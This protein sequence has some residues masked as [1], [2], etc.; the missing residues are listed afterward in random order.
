MV[1]IQK[2]FAFSSTVEYHRRRMLSALFLI[3]FVCDWKSSWNFGLLHASL[4]S[5][6]SAD[7]VGVSS[8]LTIGFSLQCQS[9]C[10]SNILS[11]YSLRYRL[12]RF[13]YVRK[14][15]VASI[16]RRTLRLAILR[17]GWGLFVIDNRFQLAESVV[18]G[19]SLV[20]SE[21]LCV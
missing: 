21:E 6:E 2:N 16:F 1:A 13:V 19:W 9:N 15:M 10:L 14:W 3:N 12:L 17:G 7:D 11:C 4:V 8:S 18:N 5:D 20:Y